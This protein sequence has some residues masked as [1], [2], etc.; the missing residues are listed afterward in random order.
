MNCPKCKSTKFVKNGIVKDKQRYVCNVCKYNYTVEKKITAKD[1]D[2]KRNALEMYLEG[3]GFRSIG[4]LL[5]TSH[6]SIYNWIKAFGEEINQIRSEGKIEVVEIDEMHTYIGQKKTTAGFGL[7]L[8]DM[9]K[10]SLIAFSEHA[11]LKQVNNFG[12]K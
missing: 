11:E 9:G 10:N 3:L 12:K 2:V 5:K 8:I 1:S 7:L 6:V 4:R